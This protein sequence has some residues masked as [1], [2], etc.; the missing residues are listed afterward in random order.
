MPFGVQECGRATSRAE[1]RRG[2]VRRLLATTPAIMVAVNHAERDAGV[3]QLV[4]PYRPSDRDAVVRLWSDC[5]LLRPWADPVR[6]IERKLAHDAEGLL[7]LQVD[8]RVVG[9][10]MA[11]YDGHRGWVNYLAVD[12]AHQR[13]GFASLLMAEVERRL[14]IAGCPKI[15][16]QVRT[17]NKQVLA[18]YEGLGY[19]LDEVVSMGKRLTD[20]TEPEAGGA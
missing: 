4:R 16:V 10:V 12:P 9:S 17:S 19:T 3:R 2:G 8:G 20:D 15:N 11:G 14:T 5:G 7:V 6:D 18:F 1:R 13:R